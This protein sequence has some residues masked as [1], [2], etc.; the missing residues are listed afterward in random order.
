[1][2]P[3]NPQRPTP[4]PIEDDIVLA[5]D[6]DIVLASDEIALEGDAPV[7]VPSVAEAEAQAVAEVEQVANAF[8]TGEKEQ[9]QRFDDATDSEY[10]F[11]LCF[12]T[13]EQKEEFLRK[14]RWIDF[15][16]K[17]LDGMTCARASGITLESRIPPQ[18]SYT[19]DTGFARL[20]QRDLPA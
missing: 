2:R 15:G 4:R 17:Y 9:D 18:R 20:A 7:T 10:W 1:M 19:I 12:Q 13:R 6:D 16:D 8:R 14:M 5:S 11:A 3:A